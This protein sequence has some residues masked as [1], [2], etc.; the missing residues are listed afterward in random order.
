MGLPTLF[1]RQAENFFSWTGPLSTE[2]FLPVPARVVQQIKEVLERLAKRPGFDD[3]VRLVDERYATY[4]ARVR[5][6]AQL[7]REYEEMA[8][9]FC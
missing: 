1:R 7:R 3:I 5:S 9:K 6:N 4:A 2:N 8:K